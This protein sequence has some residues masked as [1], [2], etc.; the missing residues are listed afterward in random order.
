VSGEQQ[1]RRL[2]VIGGG[3][4]AHRLCE[5][6]VDLGVTRRIRVVVFAEEA[7]PA[8]D[9][10]Q[11]TALVGGSAAASLALSPLAWYAGHGIDWRERDRVE[12]VDADERVIATGRAA[13]H[14]DAVTF[15]TGSQPLRPDVPGA[16]LPGVHVYR[17]RADVAGVA[18]AA[19][20]CGAR[21]GRAAVLGGGLL[22]L[23]VASALAERG[24]EVAIFERGPRLLPRQLDERASRLL[25]V[26]V[27]ARR[28]ELHTG[29]ALRAI[30]R[31]PLG[32]RLRLASGKAHDVEFLVVA[33]GVRPRDEL[34]RAA[35]VDCHPAGGIRVDD[36][37]ATSHAGV[38]AIGEV[39]RHRDRLYGLVAPGLAMADVLAARLAGRDARFAEVAPATRLKLPGIE[40]SVVGDSLG[41]GRDQRVLVHESSVHS[42]SLVLRAG[43]LAG[44]ISV[45]A[46]PGWHAVQE[47]V[48]RGARVRPASERRFQREGE[49]WGPSAARPVTVW[50]DDAIVCSCAGVSCGALRRALADGHGSVVALAAATRAGTLCGSCRPLVGELCGAP[51]ARIA[52]VPVRGL[53]TAAAA[54]GVLAIALVAVPSVAPLESVQSQPAYDA[55]WRDTFVRK[56][57]GSA[58]LA[59]CCAS[60][61]LSLRKRWRRFSLGSFARWRSLHAA[62]GVA[63]MLAVAAHTGLRL[64][65]HL[66]RAL[67]I[68][69]LA[70]SA[71]GGLAGATAALERRAPAGWGGRLRRLGHAAH[72]LVFWPFLA[73]VG[74]HVWKV[75]WF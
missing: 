39:A 18:A 2:A 12:R 46:W 42:R 55:L 73:L 74:F 68:G 16:E 60:L 19:R 30:E 52:E 9:R 34:A 21:G 11:L 66:D 33:A 50:S 13:Y 28:F 53:L 5:R 58:A 37:L 67:M 57:T 8:Y 24:C 26:H 36:G 71:L 49:L 48:A 61:A 20:E 59:L 56:L 75:L 44:A 23:E 1:R 31:G 17:T 65:S 70:L 15:A 43:Q 38:Y 29:A 3:M 22:G 62:L 63:A 6:L 54:V 7:G 10:V 25:D 35:G 14:F 41:A 27:R 64:G 4:T 32:V 47:A 40:V 51:P 45:G 72:L 69:F